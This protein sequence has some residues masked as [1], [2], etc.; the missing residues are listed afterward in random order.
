MENKVLRPMEHAEPSKN[1]CLID[2]F[3][4]S[5]AMYL[6]QG[7]CWSLIPRK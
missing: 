6:N 2:K 5:V 3:E 7:Q 4:Q 1:V